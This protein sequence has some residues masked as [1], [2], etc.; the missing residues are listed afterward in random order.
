MKLCRSVLI[1][2]VT[3]R[4]NMRLIRLCIGIHY[5]RLARATEQDKYIHSYDG[6]KT[7]RYDSC[8]F[9]LKMKESI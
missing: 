8:E 6:T 5:L 2:C 3:S 1:T 4:V 7:I 9:Q